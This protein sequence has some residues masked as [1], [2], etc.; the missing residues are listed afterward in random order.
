MT[1]GKPRAAPRPDHADETR[2]LQRLAG[3]IGD[4]LLPWNASDFRQRRFVVAAGVGLATLVSIVWLLA[5]AGRIGANATLGWWIGWSVFEVLLRLQ[6]KPWI[7]DGPWWGNNFR[8]AN[9]MDM[10][11]YVSFKNLL[12]AAGLFLAMRVLGVVD[13]LQGLPALKWLHA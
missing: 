3:E 5:A 2:P 13:F 12:I 6:S 11:C 7:K 4:H 9:L 1:A 10:I 8:R